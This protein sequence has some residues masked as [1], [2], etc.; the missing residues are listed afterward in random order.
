MASLFEAEAE[1]PPSAPPEPK[2]KKAPTAAFKVVPE[3]RPL[4]T[5]MRTAIPPGTALKK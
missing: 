4:R 5:V 3:T 2:S 1:A